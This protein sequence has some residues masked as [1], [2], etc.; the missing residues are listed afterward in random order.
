MPTKLST[1]F[2][3]LSLGIERILKVA[4]VHL[5]HDQTTDVDELEKFFLKF[6]FISD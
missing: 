5:E 6:D 4:V 3:Y 1:F 2:Y